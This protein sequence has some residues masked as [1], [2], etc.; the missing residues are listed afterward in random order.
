ML[1]EMHYDEINA[2]L[3]QMSHDQRSDDLMVAIAREEE[4]KAA[5]PRLNI[6]SGE[7]QTF[8]FFDHNLKEIQ[9]VE[10]LF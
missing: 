4:T 8:V 9:C 1:Y 5:T 10:H 3:Q 2:E 6:G 7:D